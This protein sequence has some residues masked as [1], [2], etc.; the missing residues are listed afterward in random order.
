MNVLIDTNVIL[1]ILL[2]RKS[3]FEDAVQYIAG[4]S[5]AADYIITRNTKHYEKSTIKAIT[6]KAFLNQ[7]SESKAKD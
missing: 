6:P 4:R 5:I 1:D 2:R 3:F 7:I